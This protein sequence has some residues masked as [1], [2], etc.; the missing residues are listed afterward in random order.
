MIIVSDL[1]FF[2]INSIIMQ[3]PV[4]LKYLKLCVHTPY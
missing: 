3:K 1:T 2:Y 4:N